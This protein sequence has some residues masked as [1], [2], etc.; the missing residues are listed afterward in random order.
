MK[1]CI[2]CGIMIED[3]A[4]FCRICGAFQRPKDMGRDGR[5]STRPFQ[6]APF[7][8]PATGAERVLGESHQKYLSRLCVL[9]IIISVMGIF[10]AVFKIWYG[11]G[12]GI[13]SIVV[14]SLA[15]YYKVEYGDTCLILGAICTILS[16]S[17][18]FAYSV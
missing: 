9:G 16:S 6:T 11:A 14:G 18:P 13:F 1:E 7:E 17:L 10:M 4:R 8:A 2:E 3:D 15:V 5:R 12:Y